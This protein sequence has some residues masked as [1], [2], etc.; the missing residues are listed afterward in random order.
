MVTL[1]NII[2]P[3]QKRGHAYKSAI[4]EYL[5]AFFE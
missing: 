5:Y 3:L 1:K 2:K 4:L